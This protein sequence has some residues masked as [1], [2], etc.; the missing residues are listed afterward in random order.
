[1]SANWHRL[2]FLIVKNITQDNRL[3]KLT[4]LSMSIGQKIDNWWRQLAIVDIL[5]KY[6]QD[7]PI[8]LLFDCCVC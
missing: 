3:D 8:M 1:M 7:G 5:F 2:G 6:C 4:I